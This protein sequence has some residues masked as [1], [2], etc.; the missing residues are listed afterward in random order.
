MSLRGRVF[1]SV[2]EPM[3]SRVEDAGLHAAR[4][5]L[6]ADAKGDVLE[7]GA[8]TGLNVGVYGAGVATLTL[9]EP[10]PAMVRRLDTRAGADRPDA[11]VLRAPAEDL[12]FP[13]DTFDVAVSTLVL[14]TVDD[15]PRALRE[16]RRVLRPGGELRFIE[17][18][19][20]DE[21]RLARWQDRLNGLNRVLGY[22]CNCNRPTLD[23]IRA[24]GF[25]VRTVERRP[26]LKA[27]PL[28]R[29]LVIGT[30]GTREAPEYS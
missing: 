17:H 28:V 8:G 3:M 5:Q 25:T 7:I 27:P 15:Q 14:C 13:D 6:L 18:V 4:R 11:L 23:A 30:A 21:P 16:L 22:G 24:A 12:P 9:T 1:A 26:L 19:R 29:P 2:Y 10:E 20:A